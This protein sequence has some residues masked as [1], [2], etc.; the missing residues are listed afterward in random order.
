MYCPHRAKKQDVKAIHPDG[1]DVRNKEEQET[2]TRRRT[3][4]S[5]RRKQ[6]KRRGRRAQGPRRCSQATSYPKPG[7]TR[8]WSRGAPATRAAS[9]LGRI[10]KDIFLGTNVINRGE[11][12]HCTL[13]S[14]KESSSTVPP[15]PLFPR[16]HRRS[17]G[18]L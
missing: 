4:Q 12:T 11:L 10:I 15:S 13:D 16:L 9:R 2:R 3:Q 7:C 6:V 5:Q 14:Q 17:Q 1:K 18:P 8:S